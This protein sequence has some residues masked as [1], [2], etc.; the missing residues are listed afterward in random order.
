MGL[1]GPVDWVEPDDVSEQA[2]LRSA[3]ITALAVTLGGGVGLALGGGYGLVSGAM[4]VAG[5]A[6]AYRAQKWWSSDDPSEKH[7]AVVSA[8]MAVVNLGLFGYTAY[9]AYTSK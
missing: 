6:N 2:A 9:K 7:E 8:M 1:Q 5:A 3:G 4:V